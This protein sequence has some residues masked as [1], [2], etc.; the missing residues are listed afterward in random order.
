MKS[1]KYSFYIPLVKRHKSALGKKNQK[2][3]S[4]VFSH[5]IA[6]SS[7][8]LAFTHCISRKN[9]KSKSLVSGC[10]SFCFLAAQ[11][12]IFGF[13]FIKLCVYS[14]LTTWEPGLLSSPLL[15]LDS[16]V[17]LESSLSSLGLAPPKMVCVCMVS[18]S[19]FTG[20][21]TVRGSSFSLG[22]EADSSAIQG[23]ILI[24]LLL[25]QN[26]NTYLGL[27]LNRASLGQHVLSTRTGAEMIAHLIYVTHFSYKTQNIIIKVA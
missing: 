18:A 1:G 7:L 8:S 21:L 4:T 19:W 25:F 6:F 27:G 13:F 26:A 3:P 16:L 17:R 10:V 14:W 11:I 23:I 5:Q 24:I 22:R 15:S 12:I 2:K 20:S 9:G